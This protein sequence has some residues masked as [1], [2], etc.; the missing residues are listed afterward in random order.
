MIFDEKIL[1]PIFSNG[2]IIDKNEFIE[3]LNPKK[4]LL[5]LDFMHRSTSNMHKITLDFEDEDVQWLF[6]PIHI[7]KIF[8]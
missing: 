1:K 4:G 7:R 8:E 3:F 2:A 6:S 5:N